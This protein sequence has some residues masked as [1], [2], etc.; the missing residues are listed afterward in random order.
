MWNDGFLPFLLAMFLIFGTTKSSCSVLRWD[1]PH[2]DGAVASE[3]AEPGS[4]E[5]TKLAA[6]VPS[7]QPATISKR[8]EEIRVVFTVV[9]RNG[10]FVPDVNPDQIDVV[11]NGKVISSLSSF[12]RSSELP[13]RIGLLVDVSESMTSGFASE[14]RAA[15]EFLGRVV[16][17]ERDEAFLLPFATKVMGR[18]RYVQQSTV[19]RAMS[20]YR[21]GGQ[22]A[23]Y[24]AICSASRDAVMN[25]DENVPVR[26]VIV[27]LSDGDDTES[28][29]A[30]QDAIGWA[31]RAEIA[32]YPITV[33]VT[34]HKRR[35]DYPGDPVLREIASATGG[36]FFIA[37]NYDQ[38]T[39]VF[40]RIEN[41]LR[42]QY[43]LTYLRSQAPR[44]NGFH[45]LQ[46]RIRNRPELKVYYRRGYFA[47]EYEGN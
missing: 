38:V 37:S 36:E 2:R 20:S 24:D 43:V 16:R 14:Q 47:G 41:E 21:A 17:S 32:L 31:Q 4:T 9:D 44:S 28:M 25:A 11:D 35:R 34:V 19:V 40:A 27:L 6:A 18:F 10:R 29:H 5:A 30:M 22:T 12:S 39:A 33:H 23:L 1:D 8:V 45:T 46:L 3:L 42:S 13:L 15:A 7:W 26:R